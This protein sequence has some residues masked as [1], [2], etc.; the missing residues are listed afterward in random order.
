MDVK[1]QLFLEIYCLNGVERTLKSDHRKVTKPNNDKKKNKSRRMPQELSFCIFSAE[2]LHIDHSFDPAKSHDIS[3]DALKEFELHENRAATSINELEVPP[4]SIVI[5]NCHGSKG[6]KLYLRSDED[7]EEDVAI[8]TERLSDL[9][10]P[11]CKLLIV[12][13]CDSRGVAKEVMKQNNISTVGY[14]DGLEN[15]VADRFLNTLG[16]SLSKKSLSQSVLEACEVDDDF[17]SFKLSKLNGCSVKKTKEH[18]EVPGKQSSPQVQQ[19]DVTIN[20][21]G[22]SKGQVFVQGTNVHL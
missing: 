1:F 15:E 21:Q 4:D 16:E 5:F 7:A 11:N 9:L 18:G 22:N 2:V 12:L 20:S 19:K 8:S 3:K 17:C 10:K 14:D 13:A 6:N